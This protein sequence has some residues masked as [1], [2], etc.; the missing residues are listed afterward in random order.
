MTQWGGLAGLVGGMLVSA[1]LTFF[2]GSLFTIDDPFLYIS[3]WSF[4]GSLIIGTAVTLMTQPYPIERLR[5]LVYGMVVHDDE[6]QD[7]IKKNIE[8]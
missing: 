1:T 5:G 8:E 4:V 7:E 2:K 3:W 6:L